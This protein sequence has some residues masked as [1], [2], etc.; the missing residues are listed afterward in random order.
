M[1]EFSQIK[2]G[3][4]IFLRNFIAQ[5]KIRKKWGN[6]GYEKGKKWVIFGLFLK[7]K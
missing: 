1:G 4:F 5:K 3:R 2:N 7:K 6:Q